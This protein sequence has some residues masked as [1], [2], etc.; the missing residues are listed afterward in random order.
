MARTPDKP[1]TYRV[2]PKG[3][4]FLLSGVRAN[5]T[6]FKDTLNSREEAER[7]GASVFGASSVAS[8]PLL[9]VP[10]IV[11][12]LDEFGVPKGFTLPK[13]SADTIAVMLPKTD[14]SG[15]PPPKV[16]DAETK[17]KKEKRLKQAKSVAEMIGIAWVSADIWVA[18]NFLESRYE[19]VPKPNV[20]QNNDL[21]DAVKDALAESFGDREIGKWTFVFLMTIGIPLSMWLQ[22]RKPKERIK[23]EAKPNLQSVP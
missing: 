19:E 6:R 4:Q 21:A 17:E 16:E 9:S 22:S 20:K 7:L 18:R 11:E 3:G 5:G 10:T 15:A 8:K 12:E 1:G 14:A 23:A 2:T 13:V